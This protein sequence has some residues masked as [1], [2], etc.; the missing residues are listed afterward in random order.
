MV[1]I[2]PGMAKGPT[3]IMT[4]KNITQNKLNKLF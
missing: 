1:S 2:I 3:M 4:L